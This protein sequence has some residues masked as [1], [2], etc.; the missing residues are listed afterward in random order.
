MIG[1]VVCNSS[2]LIA[3]H[4]IDQLGLLE[5]L[6]GQVVIPP[7][8]KHEAIS[9]GRLPTWVVQCPL[10]DSPDLEP[11]RLYLGEGEAQ[12]I[13]LARELHAV[14]IILDDRPA[15][16]TAEAFAIPVIGTLGML[17]A[18]KQRG[19]ILEIRPW[20]DRLIEQGFRVAPGLYERVLADAGEP[21]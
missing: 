18:G 15:R 3:L 20:M 9:I 19:R 16:R 6:F 2:P 21:L 4:Q 13:L 8:V 10:A 17:W 11:L 5:C 1:K 14:K 7:A 12:A